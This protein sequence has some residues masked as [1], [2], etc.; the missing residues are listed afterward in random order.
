M[1]T[2]LDE[3]CAAHVGKMLAVNPGLCFLSVANNQ[4][5]RSAGLRKLLGPLETQNRTLRRWA[6]TNTEHRH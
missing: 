2:G 4:Q 6:E 1:Q 5:L 3:V